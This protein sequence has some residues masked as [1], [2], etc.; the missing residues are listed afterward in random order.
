MRGE[1]PKVRPSSV[2]VVVAGPPDAERL[3]GVLT[4]AD[5]VRARRWRQADDQAR[6]IV[7]S[8]LLRIAAASMLG[9]GVQAVDLG[10]WC[11]RC[12][13]TDHGRPVALGP[14]GRPVPA[15]HLSAS[16]AGGLVV[17]AVTGAG[18]VGVDVERVGAATFD[19]FPRTVLTSREQR[20]L[21]VVP[22]TDQARWCTRLWTRKE[23]L[24]KALGLG[25]TVDPSRVDVL[26]PA[27]WPEGLTDGTW[28]SGV[29][30]YQAHLL[31]L[32]GVAPTGADGPEGQPGPVGDTAGPGGG[33]V[34]TVALLAAGERPPALTVFRLPPGPVDL[35]RISDL[36]E[37]AHRSP[38]GQ[39]P[40]EVGHPEVQPQL[41]GSAVDPST[42]GEV[43]DT[44]PER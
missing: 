27:R 7:A 25:L 42:D 11:P 41:Y 30:H 37:P 24:L 3:A 1:D 16:H 21:T 2:S 36:S 35:D 23:A 33:H 34:G 19:E 13:L 32:P 31:D 26:G 28:G 8:A 18:P 43:Q 22:E 17:V 10:R 39:V 15:V 4:S 29:D 6:S 5:T 9:T 20:A 40:E 12:G 14:G 38:A 44:Q